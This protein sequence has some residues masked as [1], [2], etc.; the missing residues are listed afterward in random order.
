M[1]KNLLLSLLLMATGVCMAATPT[2]YPDLAI[3]HISP[4]G[5]Y[6]TSEAYGVMVIVDTQTEEQYLYADDGSWTYEYTAG[7]GNCWS[8]NGILVG[9]ET[10]EGT[11]SYWENG[12]WDRLPNPDERAVYLTCITPAGD[13]IVGIVSTVDADGLPVDYT[14]LVGVWEKGD[15][16]EWT[17]PVILPA[18]DKDFTGRIP[19][20]VTGMRISDDGKC[21]AGQFLDYSG[22]FPHPIIYTQD[23]DGKWQYKVVASHLINP[24]G[25]EFPEFIDEG[26]VSPQPEDYLSPEQREAW[27]TAYQL[28]IESGYSTEYPDPADYIDEEGA[29]RYNDDVT[30]YNEEAEKYNEMLEAFFEVFNKMYD[31]MPT[32]LYNCV[33]M[34]AGGTHLAVT[35][36]YSVADDPTDPWSAS[37]YHAVPYLID[38]VA[39]THTTH[40][41]DVHPIHINELSADGTMVGYTESAFRNTVVKVPGGE[42]LPLE[43]LIKEKAPETYAWM[44]ENMFHDYMYADPWTGEEVSGTHEPFTGVAVCTP[45]LKHFATYAEN[46][47]DFDDPSYVY[48]YH[49]PTPELSGIIGVAADKATLTVKVLKGGYITLSETADLE[50]FDMQGRALFSAKGVSGNVATSLPEGLYTV[51]AKAGNH[52]VVLKAIF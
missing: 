6:L 31:E 13:R 33:F 23:A 9:S 46:Y 26:P 11:P 40:Q 30:K 15:N 29:A 51:K 27:N 21:I 49:I 48:S 2:V 45:D 14:D 52:T 4:D 44:E 43:Q 42:W 7:Q 36:T 22:M 25:R 5:R 28:W 19:S 18:P 47:W 16:G 3:S 38:L 34:T 39:D 10:Y 37:T 35:N 24:E 12:E 32:F 17:G 8:R 20:R 1:K 41:H 50:V